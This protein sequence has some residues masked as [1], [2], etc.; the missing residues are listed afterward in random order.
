MKIL[1]DTHVLLWWLD[2]P[3]LLSTKAREAISNEENIVFVSAV[4]IWEITIKQSLGKLRI[5]QGIDSLL[6][7]DFFTELPVSILHARMV[8]QLSN[9]HSDPFD[10]LL[11]AQSLLEKA[12]LVTRDNVFKKYEVPLIKA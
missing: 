7:K 10:R 4:S 1:L 3:S 6:H 12:L 2:D 9:V 11:I 5:P 8:G